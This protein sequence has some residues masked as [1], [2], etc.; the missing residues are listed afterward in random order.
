MSYKL[1]AR[2]KAGS[3]NRAHQELWEDRQVT[4]KEQ[5]DLCTR[6]DPLLLL[7]RDVRF[8]VAQQELQL[9]QGERVLGSVEDIEDIKVR[10]A[11][12]SPGTRVQG[13]RPSSSLL[14]QGNIGDK[15]FM[16]VTNLRLIWVL[17]RK[18]KI[19]LSIGIGAV[20]NIE[21]RKAQTR[22]GATASL[23]L[24]ASSGTVSP[25]LQHDRAYPE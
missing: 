23:L 4:R 6:V 12:P 24:N 16:A 25:L 7:D 10:R 3:S 19:N 18:P 14:A 1:D 2:R 11:A 13:N 8:D 20:M 17:T 21:T 22:M 5:V 15:G 9:R